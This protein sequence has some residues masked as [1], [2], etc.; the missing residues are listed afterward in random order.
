MDIPKRISKTLRLDIGSSANKRQELK[1][2]FN[3]TFDLY[4]SLF[5]LICRDEAYYE[6]AEPLRHPLIFYFGHTATFFINKLLLAKL[7]ETRINPEFE[8]M[9]AIGVDEMSWDDL[10]D[11]HYDWPSV[12]AVQDYRD[13]VR[14]RVNQLIDVVP[15]TVPIRQEDPG[16]TILMG[17]EHERIHLETSSVIIRM[18][19]MASV[20]LITGW[21]S[22][23]DAGAA[24]ANT[25]VNV[26]QQSVNLG[27]SETDTPL[28]AGTMNTATKM[29]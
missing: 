12:S 9:F 3:Q 19:P 13:Q 17:I 16:W 2:Y 24:P 1:A 28:T 18:L 25:L 15:L 20:Q 4:E 27:K 26:S 7:I 5:K 21:E 22:C 23:H 8:A 11:A 29:S 10:N 6:Q 14:A